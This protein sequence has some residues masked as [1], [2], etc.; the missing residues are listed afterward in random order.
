[1][2][3]WKISTPPEAKD[4]TNGGNGTEET[5]PA[6]SLTTPVTPTPPAT[7]PEFRCEEH[8][9]TFKN[10]QGLRLHQTR[11]HG[12]KPVTEGRFRKT[13]AKT[14]PAAPPPAVVSFD[15][16]KALATV[17]PSGN[18]PVKHFN[19]VHAWLTEA[20]TLHGLLGD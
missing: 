7:P 1:M 2:E 17:S 18:V 5:K 11:A 9:K 8:N 16:T 4:E 15:H 14:P 12:V 13:R 6:T 10:Q 20:E 19:R 3:S